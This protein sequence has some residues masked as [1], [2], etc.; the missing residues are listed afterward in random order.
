[1]HVVGIVEGGAERDD[2]LVAA[3]ALEH[4]GHQLPT[5]L[6]ARLDV[7]RATEGVDELDQRLLGNVAVA[8]L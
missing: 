7:E 5:A 8:H 2:A 4:V 1:M 6:A 3:R